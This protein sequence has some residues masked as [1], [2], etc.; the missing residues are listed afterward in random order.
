MTAFWL[1][2]PAMCII[3]RF[4][5]QRENKRRQQMLFEIDSESDKE[6]VIET[7]SEVVKISDRDLDRTDRQNLKFIYPL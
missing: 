7:G 2:S 5:L 1:I 4:Y 6:E 3:I